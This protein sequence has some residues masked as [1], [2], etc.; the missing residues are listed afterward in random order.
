MYDL[1]FQIKPIKIRQNCRRSFS[2]T[3]GDTSVYDAMVRMAQEWSMRYRL[4]DGQGNF[5]SVDGDSLQQCVTLRL[6]CVRFR[7]KYGRYRKRC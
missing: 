6:E 4:V 5:G 7:K 2:I 3:L 1:V